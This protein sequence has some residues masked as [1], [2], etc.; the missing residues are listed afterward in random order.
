MAQRP[1]NH[2]DVRRRNQKQAN[3][4]VVAKRSCERGEEVL[5]TVS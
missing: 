4:V 1:D 5:E 2:K 3:G